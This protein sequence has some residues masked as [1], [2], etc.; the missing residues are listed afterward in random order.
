[1]KGFRGKSI[2]LALVLLLVAGLT[3]VLSGWVM[4]Q[5]RDPIGLTG[6]LWL[7][8]DSILDPNSVRL[9]WGVRAPVEKHLDAWI[10]EVRMK[11]NASVWL[12]SIWYGTNQVIYERYGSVFNDTVTIDVDERT[13][14]M[15]WAWYLY[16]PSSANV[17]LHTVN[18]TYWAVRRPLHSI[19]I[20][21]VAAGMVIFMVS[22]S[23]LVQRWLHAS[24]RWFECRWFAIRKARLTMSLRSYRFCIHH[25]SQD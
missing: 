16:N 12:R 19:G 17:R 5:R 7:Q 25:R 9:A 3:V 1:L 15:E 23:K 6:E 21:T 18:V 8:E 20:V 2:D 24:S 22:F 11:A 10:F 4:M 13:S 14:G